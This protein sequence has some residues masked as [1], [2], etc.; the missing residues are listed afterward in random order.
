MYNT[1]HRFRSAGPIW[2]DGL[3]STLDSKTAT[4]PKQL[5]ETAAKP[6]FADSKRLS[7]TAGISKNDAAMCTPK[8]V[9]K[10]HKRQASGTPIQTPSKPSR[11]IKKK[12]EGKSSEGREQV[13]PPT[14][15]MV[16]VSRSTNG[17][18]Q[19]NTDPFGPSDGE[20]PLLAS[21]IPS[22]SSPN[23]HHDN[24]TAEPTEVDSNRSS[25]RSNTLGLR[26]VDQEML[27]VDGAEDL[28]V[29]V[30]G[31]TEVSGFSGTQPLSIPIL[32]SR[33]GQADM[34]LPPV[35][36]ECPVVSDLVRDSEPDDTIVPSSTTNAAG[37]ISAPAADKRHGNLSAAL[38]GMEWLVPHEPPSAL[39]S[40]SN[41]P[42]QSH[43]SRGPAQQQTLTRYMI[44][45]QGS[46]QQAPAP[47]P[48]YSNTQT[49]LPSQN[50]SSA[51]LEL[52]EK[53]REEQREK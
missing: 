14:M 36:V 9:Q 38:F 1:C 8:A 24:G 41:V 19:S 46:R 33:A 17:E 22:P 53:R 34:T 35:N 30:T 2:A 52:S 27:E 45:G 47:P 3:D 44:K 7:T 18:S 21:N 4:K 39:P 49:V 48:I 26:D 28:T 16:A 51:R 37:V 20:N 31:D 15:G 42:H 32:L 6:G 25:L 23:A 11:Q 10:H 50:T 13:A 40:Q 43:G 12:M 29:S 5:P